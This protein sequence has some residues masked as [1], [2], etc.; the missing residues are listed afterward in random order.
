MKRTR[1]LFVLALIF[2]FIA[3]LLWG[4]VI[5][6]VLKNP[7]YPIN[8]LWAGILILAMIFTMVGV[9]VF[10]ISEFLG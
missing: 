3:A 9:A 5:G 10:L 7:N 2:S 1:K 6:A 4:E 8:L